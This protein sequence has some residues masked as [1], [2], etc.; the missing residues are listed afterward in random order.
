MSRIRFQL[1]LLVANVHLLHHRFTLNEKNSEGDDSSTSSENE[2]DKGHRNHSKSEVTPSEIEES[3]LLTP[4][5]D[6]NT[7][8]ERIMSVNRKKRCIDDKYGCMFDTQKG[9]CIAIRKAKNISNMKTGMFYYL[10]NTSKH[11]EINYLK[12]EQKFEYLIIIFI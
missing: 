4:C 12:V 5:H 1:G 2:C 9:E 11:I 8:M 3:K 7:F 10:F 6:H